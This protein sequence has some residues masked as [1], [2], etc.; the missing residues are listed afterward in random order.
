MPEALDVRIPNHLNVVV[1]DKAIVQN[2]DIR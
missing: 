2:V 1:I